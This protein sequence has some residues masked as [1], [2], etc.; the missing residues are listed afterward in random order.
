MIRLLSLIQKNSIILLRNWTSLLVL[1]LGPVI[2]ILLIGM[3]FS[4]VGIRNIEVGVNVDEQHI[5]SEIFEPAKQFIHLESFEHDTCI[6]A[7]HRSEIMLC[8]HVQDADNPMQSQ[9]TILYDNSQTVMS[10]IIVNYMKEYFGLTSEDMAIESAQVLLRNVEQVYEFAQDAHDAIGVQIGQIG[11]FIDSLEQF[12]GELEQASHSFAQFRLELSRFERRVNQMTDQTT[13]GASQA[14]YDIKTIRAD[15]NQRNQQLINIEKSF[16]E[17]ITHMSELDKGFFENRNEII[18][19]MDSSEDLSDQAR[20]TLYTIM[21]LEGLVNITQ[22]ESLRADLS[23]VRRQLEQSDRMLS[24]YEQQS[25]SVAEQLPAIQH[26]FRLLAS[27][28]NQ[29]AQ[30]FNTTITFGRNS[31]EVFET[32]KLFMEKLQKELVERTQNLENIRVDQ[33]GTFINPLMALFEPI[34]PRSP[35]IYLLFPIV[36]PI[37]IIFISMLFS[38]IIVLEEMHSSAQIRNFIMPIK[39]TMLILGFWLTA[40]GIIWVQVC[41]IMMYAHFKLDIPIL[42]Q[43]IPVVVVSSLLI[44]LFV[45]LGMI[46]ALISATKENSILIT[47]F[48]S[49]GCFF[50]SNTLVPIQTMQPIISILVS[51]NPAVIAATIYRRT[52]FFGLGLRESLP[53]VALLLLYVIVMFGVLIYIMHYYRQTYR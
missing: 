43:L 37:I 35:Q 33:A 50:F 31:L 20:N 5:F 27:Q 11:Q 36:L 19:F 10:G 48:V 39:D 3:V 38:N 41:M 46:I 9:I 28:S 21:Q 17:Y 7:L 22:L 4:G 24:E 32:N 12:I 45:L 25:L 53:E 44:G 47:T 16:D 51:L 23:D 26:E 40:F 49:V 8:V 13:Q 1:V 14:Q 52:L 42:E 15:I 30:F 6:E 18:V 29:L 2:L 34:I